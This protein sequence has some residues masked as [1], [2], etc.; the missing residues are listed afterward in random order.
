M[1]QTQRSQPES[2]MIWLAVIPP[3]LWATSFLAAK[4]AVRTI[5]PFTAAA[6]RFVLVA[7]ILWTLLFLFK[8]GQRVIASQVPAL[9]LTGLFQTTLYF[10]FQY[11]GLT[12]STASIGSILV[13]TR[14]IFVTL[15]A[16]LLL[17]EKLTWPKACGTGVAFAGVILITGLGS[18]ASLSL[19]SEQMLGDV[20]FLLNALS[21]A[22]G[23]VLT[24]RVLTQFK[25]LPALVYTSS[26]GA[27]GLWPFA[28][29]ELWQGKTVSFDSPA[30]WLAL[31]YQ[32]IFTSV[33]A[34]LV[35]NKVLSRTEASWAAVFLYITPVMTVVLSWA[36]LG[37]S[38]TWVLTLGTALVILGTHLVSHR[39]P[40]AQRRQMC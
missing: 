21:G 33:V 26:F 24:K 34:H 28:A 8:A 6:F 1:E 14:P 23:L 20:L 35:W 13:N 9:A 12:L 31:V 30:P 11:A 37:E 18:P 32:A 4:Y 16:V 38:L 36:L 2:Y 3:S 29:W 10:A 17:R 22:I 27:L 5:P 40:V 39:A 19:T 7:G 25:P 15:I